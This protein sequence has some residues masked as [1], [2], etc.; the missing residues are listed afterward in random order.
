MKTSVAIFKRDLLRLLRNPIALAIA[1]GVSIVPCLYAW[2]NIA[3]NWD[4]YA[5]T[6]TMP[7]AVV[8]EDK[9]VE[10]SDMGEICVGDM[11]I[12]KLAENDK[13]G[14][15]FP[16]T[17][18][19]ALDKVKTGTY[20]ATIVIPEDFTSSLTGV[21]D[22]KTS[23]AHLKYYVNEKANAI[24]PKVT[25]TGASTVETTIDEQ[26]VAVAGE[27]IA[28]KLG[29]LA[30]KL[31]KGVDKAADNVASSLAEARTALEKVDGKLDGLS[32]SLLGAQTS[33]TDA[34]NRLG[35]LQ[36]R[37]TEAANSINDAL[38]NF[39]QTRANASNLMFDISNTLGAGASTISSL[40]SQA[41]YDV[42]LL[43]GDIAYAK[44]QV[45]GAI[46]QLESDLTDN[47]A[48]TTKVSE[49]LA[50]VQSL[51]PQDDAGAAE[52]KTLL[53]QQLSDEQS[54]LV[55]LSSSQTAK[56]DELRSIG[57]RLDGA[58]EEVRG[59]SRGVDSRVQ[60]ALTSLQ[61]AQTEAVGNDLNEVNA[62]LDSFVGVARQLEAAARL[63]DPTVEQTVN[64]ANQL[65]ETLGQTND[66]VAS[67]R[68][69]LGELIGSVDSLMQELEVIRASDTWALLKVM[70]STNP[71]GVKEFLSAPVT[72]SENRLYPVDNYGSGVAP[73]FTSVALWVGGIALVAVF[74]LEVD[75]E[76]VGRVRPWQA[77]FGRWMLFVLLGTL[78]AI[79]CC[80]GDLLL[81]IQ[82][83]YPVAFFL[84]AI[85]AAFAFV[86][87]I[88]SLSVAFKH[89]GKAL[90]FLLI[91]LQVP[92]SAGMYPIEMMPPFFQ[93]IGPWLPFTYSNNAMREAI[94]GFYDGNLVYNL[95]MLLLFVVPSILVGVTARS[96]LVNINAL[97]DRRL[98]ETD[99]LMVSEPVAIEDD[100]FRLATLVKAM[101]D[102]KEYREVFDERS[103]SFE[104]SYT[105][106]VA[107][108]VVALFVVPLTLFV[109]ALALDTK[110]PF[111]GGLVV[112]LA[113]IYSYLIVVEYFHDRIVRKRALTD[114]SS[115]E[116]DEA[117][118]NTLRDELM[119]Y[120]PIDAII[121]RRNRRREKSIIG[122]VHKRV[123]ERR[124]QAEALDETD[125]DAS[126]GGDE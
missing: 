76:E 13:I 39:D 120:A 7:V 15:T 61:N 118:T 50:V 78:C 26:F 58:A 49:S 89:L 119:P 88:Y 123:A 73:F 112:A 51:D 11:M 63:V 111:I 55:N 117:L 54:V 85:V 67:T 68:T 98:R 125:A 74:K 64:V 87:V 116:L 30:D 20:Y 43:A 106:L 114:L 12:E 21:L 2:L 86:N 45:D 36:G 14:W 47:E 18:E 27:V 56:I 110:L 122:K 48:L 6:S 72:V 41:S 3:S 93:A 25:D 34:A 108:G 104:A 46:G 109:L 97:F 96:H 52:A 32:E 31:T 65:A 92:G 35:G 101:R 29:G 22:G 90:A 100:R 23:K 28:T 94:A 99:H 82:C 4:P 59:L 71:A 115:E 103:A 8:S 40:S 83:E 124:D 9:P 53:E 81:G 66:A 60:N 77:Y 105:K 121:E 84:S 91:I 37:G 1:L 107:R 17:E 10:M 44:A 38:A 113:V 19:E 5:N 80:T 69:S 33:L 16:E 79:V 126:K 62:A 95:L 42:S 57:A 24:A 102:P 75:E 70:A